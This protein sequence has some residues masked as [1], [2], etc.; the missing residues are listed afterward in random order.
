MHDANNECTTGDLVLIS[1][2]RPL[3][4]TKRWEVKE[5]KQKALKLNN[6][7]TWRINN[8]IQTQTYLNV[9]DN[10]G[11]KEDHVY[12]HIG[13]KPKVCDDWRCDNRSCKGCN[14]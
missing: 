1:E 4:K 8:M 7:G 6:A 13:W 12:P 14:S 11:A 10:S 5:V 2:T 3:S 9:A